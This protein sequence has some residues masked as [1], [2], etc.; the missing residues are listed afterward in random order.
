MI[1][2][3][4]LQ[5]TFQYITIILLAILTAFNYQLFITPNSF[6]PAGINGIATMIQYLLGVNAISWMSLIINVPLCILAFFLVDKDFA[7]KT[8]VFAVVFS[9]FYY[10]LKDLHFL[11][12]V[13]AKLEYKADTDTIFPVM[14]AGLTSGLVYGISFRANSS[15]GGTD[16]VAKYINKKNPFLNFFWVT[17]ILNAIVAVSSYFVYDNGYKPVCLCVL[18]CFVSSFIG[19]AILKGSKSAYKFLIITTHAKEIDDEIISTLKHSATKLVGKGVYSETDKD[20]IICVINKHQIVQF[21][22][23][24]KKYDETFAFVETVNETIGNFKQIK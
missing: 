13:T 20:V 2:S 12:E 9:I 22:N 18:Y 16:L 11:S 21:E 7:L 10:C 5:L 17:F 3:Q 1:K 15:T 4:K 23:I 14:I 6:A 19:N 24:I 8:L